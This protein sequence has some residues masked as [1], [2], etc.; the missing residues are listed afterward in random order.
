MHVPYR[1]RRDSWQPARWLRVDHLML[2]FGLV[3]IAYVRGI[4][5]LIGDDTWNSRD[6]MIAAAPEWVWGGIG[7]VAGALILTYAIIARRHLFVYIGHW[8]LG[9]AYGL[10]A[11]AAVLAS[12][13]DYAFPLVIVGCAVIAA[14][15]WAVHLLSEARRIAAAFGVVVAGVAAL[16]GIIY[17]LGTFDGI[18]G[19]GAVGLVAAIHVMQAFRTGARPIRITPEQEAAATAD[20]VIVT[21]EQEG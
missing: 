3:V 17:L 2:M 12:G 5:Y 15:T 19:G 21:G 20:E 18:R 6:F 14:G 11:M 10:N 7:F 1:A 13:P 16:A 4:D 9:I 8:W